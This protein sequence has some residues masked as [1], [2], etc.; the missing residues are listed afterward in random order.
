MSDAL[1]LMDNGY[2]AAMAR[3]IST[4]LARVYKIDMKTAYFIAFNLLYEARQS[5]MKIVGEY[6]AENW[7]KMTI[8]ERAAV[9]TEVVRGL[10]DKEKVE[11][12]INGRRKSLV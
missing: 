12:F 8:S 3:N 7:K 1:G 11:A 4:D 9:C 6:G 10:L 5:I 2:I